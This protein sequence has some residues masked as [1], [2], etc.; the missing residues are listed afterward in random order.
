MFRYDPTFNEFGFPR[1]LNKF[2]PAVN[3]VGNSDI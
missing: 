2:L 3:L 1:N